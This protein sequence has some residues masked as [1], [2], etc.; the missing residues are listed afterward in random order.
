LTQNCEKVNGGILNVETDTV[1]TVEGILKYIETKRKKFG[2]SMNNEDA[3]TH[4]T[5]FLLEI[6]F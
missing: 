3:T 6:S 1:N 5:S 2:I 4:K